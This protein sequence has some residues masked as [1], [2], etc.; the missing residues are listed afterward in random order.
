MSA[1][2]DESET[3]PPQTPEQPSQEPPRRQRVFL[4]AFL[5]SFLRATLSID[6]TFRNVW[7]Y[8]AAF[9]FIFNFSHTFQPRLTIQIAAFSANNL[10]ETLF[11][12][13]NSGSWTL[14]DLV[15]TC[16]IWNE[17]RK[18]RSRGN[19]VYSGN[20][21]LQ[22][23]P[24]ISILR[25]S[26]IATQDCGLRFLLGSMPATKST[27]IEMETTYSWLHGLKQDSVKRTYDMR[28]FSGRLVIVPDL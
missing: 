8:V 6:R 5:A 9:L 16:T 21:P 7:F 14:T 24:I 15:T 25:P 3:T 12:L 23:N 1:T 2:D 10:S 18:I 22:G 4:Q 26:D 17:G 11:T 13:G 19:Y 27:R 28:R 20:A